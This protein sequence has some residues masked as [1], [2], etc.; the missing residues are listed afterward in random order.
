M[1]LK[2]VEQGMTQ[3]AQPSAGGYYEESGGGGG[4]EEVVEEAGGSVD[5]FAELPM[6]IGDNYQEPNVTLEWSAKEGRFIPKYVTSPTTPVMRNVASAAGT[7]AR[8]GSFRG[9]KKPLGS[10]TD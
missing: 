2:N 8:L 5:P 1:I 7:R 6:N 9:S 4:G 10:A 3:S